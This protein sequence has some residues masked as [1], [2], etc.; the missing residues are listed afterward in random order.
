MSAMQEQVHNRIGY[1]P[2]TCPDEHCDSFAEYHSIPPPQTSQTSNTSEPIPRSR[3]A[4]FAGIV[5]RT[6]VPEDWLNRLSASM[7]HEISK[8]RSTPMRAESHS[9]VDLL[10]ANKSGCWACSIIVQHDAA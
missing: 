2:N 8:L 5:L 4:V 6:S 10:K 7:I 3:S 9:N 1:R